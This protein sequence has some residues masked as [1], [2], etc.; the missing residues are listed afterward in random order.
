MGDQRLEREH[1]L[2]EMDILKDP[3]LVGTAALIAHL[4][5]SC[6]IP[7]ACVSP[8]RPL[9]L[10]SRPSPEV[11]VQPTFGCTQESAYSSGVAANAR[12]TTVSNQSGPGNDD[13]HSQT[14]T[15]EDLQFTSEPPVVENNEDDGERIASR[16]ATPVPDFV[17][18]GLES[19][20]VSTP[21]EDPPRVSTGVESPIGSGTN[22]TLILEQD[23]QTS[24]VL[25]FPKH[26]IRRNVG[27]VGGVCRGSDLLYYVWLD[28]PKKN[29][30]VHTDY[31]REIIRSKK[32]EIEGFILC[33]VYSKQ[34]EWEESPGATNREIQSIL[35]D[36]QI[37][38]YGSFVSE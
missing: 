5:T 24:I 23:S 7:L 22:Q 8:S 2:G 19:P 32:Y 33:P 1:Q 11:Q 16:V 15:A 36:T 14:L 10:T 4:N 31:A 28:G 18:L 25:P 27:E 37:D 13:M 26:T 6:P 3:Q 17:A 20:L 9:L 21:I 35:K 12:S 34:Y 38:E 30:R 29:L